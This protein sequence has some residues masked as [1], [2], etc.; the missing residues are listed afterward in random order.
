[1]INAHASHLKMS[2]E[3]TQKFREMD[4]AAY[5]RTCEMK[6]CICGAILTANM[7]RCWKCG[8]GTKC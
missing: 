6:S 4:W 1:M 2:E 7:E 5:Y 3:E 8:L